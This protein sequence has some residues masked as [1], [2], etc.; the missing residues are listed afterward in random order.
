MMSKVIEMIKENRQAMLT[1]DE[2]LDVRNEIGSM[3]QDLTALKT[4][5]DDYKQRHLELEDRV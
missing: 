5:K 1:K 2:F 4:Y 3:M